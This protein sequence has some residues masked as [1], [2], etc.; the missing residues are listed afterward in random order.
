[1]SDTED[2]GGSGSIDGDGNE[3]DD[4]IGGLSQADS[5]GDDDGED[6]ESDRFDEED[7]ADADAPRI[8]QW[9]DD[10]TLGEGPV[11]EE[12]EETDEDG[13][14]VQ[15]VSAVPSTHLFLADVPSI[16]MLPAF[17]KEQ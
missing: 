3:S 9:V 17:L 7:D 4:V 14:D 6:G 12:A 2:I 15:V 16:V 1:M 10:E 5:D 8:S 13:E 11:E